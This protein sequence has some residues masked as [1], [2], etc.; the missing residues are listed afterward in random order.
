MVVNHYPLVI[1][2]WEDAWG[3]AHTPVTAFDIDAEHLPLTVQTL[4]WLLKDDD[5]GVSVF[6]ER[7]SDGGEDVWRGRSFIPRAMIKS[8]TPFKLTT[9]RKSPHEKNRPLPDPPVQSG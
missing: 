6:N 7:Y 3:G 5:K 2:V 9:P 4:G 8:V 1:I